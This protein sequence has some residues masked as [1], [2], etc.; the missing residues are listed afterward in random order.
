MALA[1]GRLLIVLRLPVGDGPLDPLQPLSD[2]HQLRLGPTAGDAF[3]DRPYIAGVA[4]M[5]GSRLP[6]PG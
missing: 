3:Q 5:P 2:I 6:I 1:S 4:D